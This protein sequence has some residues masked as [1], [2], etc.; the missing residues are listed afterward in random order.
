M[1]ISVSAGKI[2]SP[3]FV[4]VLLREFFGHFILSLLV[5]N[6]FSCNVRKANDAL[7]EIRIS[8]ALYF[9]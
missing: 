4:N 7:T 3:F 8:K 9:R 6:I 1:P 2:L 5:I